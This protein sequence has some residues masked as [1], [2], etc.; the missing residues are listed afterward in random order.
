MTK[1]RERIFRVFRGSDSQYIVFN[2]NP[3]TVVA[4]LQT[5]LWL[6][7]VHVMEWMDM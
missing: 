1:R 7:V 5:L 3:Y 2:S 6:T 4:A